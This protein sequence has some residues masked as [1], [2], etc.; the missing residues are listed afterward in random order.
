VRI[1]VEP[2]LENVQRS[3]EEIERIALADPDIAREPR[4]PEVV[5]REIQEYD[6][7]VELR[8]YVDDTRKMRRTKSRVTENILAAFEEKGIRLATPTQVVQV[9]GGENSGE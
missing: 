1:G 3:V 8:F 4:A 7:L 6:V 9:L 5:I 2:D